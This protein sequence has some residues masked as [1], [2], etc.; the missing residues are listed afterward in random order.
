MLLR[1]ITL[2][3]VFI[4]VLIGTA[5]NNVFLER[6]YWKNKPSLEQ[7]KADINKE[8]DPTTLNAHAFDAI[9]W[10]LIEKIDNEII[11]Y[12][13]TIKGNGVNKK[14]HDGRT[15]IFWAAYKDNLEMMEYLVNNGAK[16][17]IIDSHGYTLLNF[18]A[19]TGQLNT[20][21]YD[22]C[23]TH[24]ANVVSEKNH[25]GT[26]SLLLLAPSLKDE[27]LINYFT[28][29]GIDLHS[30]DNNGNG[31]F[32][33]AAKKGNTTLLDLLIKKGVAY[34]S[35]NK[36][37]GNA[38]IFASQGTRH[39]SNTLE[40]YK[41]LETLGLQP[42]ITTEN[43]FTPLHA[44]AYKNKDIDIFNYFIEKG[45]DVNQQDI[46]GNTPFINASYRNNLETITF[47]SE[48][49]KDVNV[50]NKKGLSPLMRAVENNTA[51]VVSF[52]LD[53][54]ANISA[55]DENNNTLVYFLI[56]SYSEKTKNEFYNKLQLLKNNN[57]SFSEL[58]SNNNNLWHVAVKQN[59]VDLLHKLL[60]FQVPINHKNSDGY[61][62]L[63][64]A[65]MKAKNTKILEFLLKHGA[66]KTVKTEFAETPL[67][68]ALE[69]ELLPN[70]RH[71][72]FLQ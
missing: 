11:N 29:K 19:V 60:Q 24:G 56:K 52:L 18:A 46:N 20:K 66:D 55:T 47:L 70:K 54:G 10:G 51:D 48:H 17:N 23:I 71:L 41:Y 37:G 26:N 7:V 57:L 2:T 5:Q 22:F 28:S 65:A 72:N 59:N 34:K 38:F 44:L 33:Y 62:P 25:D 35:L 45:V 6:S 4:S 27:S 16:T 1:Y 53:K 8:N 13:L 36:Q 32:N 39:H 64:I 68:L 30:V 3:L 12:L 42:D 15:Y 61:T 40:T 21:L 63:H 58:Q 9:S 69:N 14:T 49:T 43:G 67:D 31:I 50:Q